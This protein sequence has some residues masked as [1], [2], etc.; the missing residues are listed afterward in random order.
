MSVEV[1]AKVTPSGGHYYWIRKDDDHFDF[2]L[3]DD[4]GRY[5]RGF[6][7]NGKVQEFL[8][9]GWKFLGPITPQDFEALHHARQVCSAA[10]DY[11]QTLRDPL[12]KWEQQTREHVADQ[13]RQVVE[14]KR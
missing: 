1:A 14:R 13:L 2:V 9:V 4:D 6:K 10:L 5:M 7:V 11:L 3:I 8:A 12:D